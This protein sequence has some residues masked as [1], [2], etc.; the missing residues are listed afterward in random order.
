MLVCVQCSASAVRYTFLRGIPGVADQSQGRESCGRKPWTGSP[1]PE[2]L[3]R[4]PWAGSPGPEAL[5]RKPCAGSTGPE[6]L[7][8]KPCA[9]SPGPE[10]LCRKHC[11]GST[12]LDA[13]RFEGRPENLRAGSPGGA[14]RCS[15]LRF[16]TQEDGVKS[17]LPGFGGPETLICRTDR[18]SFGPETRAWTLWGFAFWS[19]DS[20]GVTTGVTVGGVARGGM[21]SGSGE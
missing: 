12:W 8:R 7:G 21:W 13:L 9:G 20:V 2:A 19:L 11:A 10:A 15:G 16:G 1:V 5:G 3:G 17:L 6:A 18:Q 4:K 14:E